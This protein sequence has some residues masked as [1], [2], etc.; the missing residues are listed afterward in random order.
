MPWQSALLAEIPFEED[1][2][3]YVLSELCSGVILDNTDVLT[4]AHCMFD[5]LTGARVPVEDMYI[6][7]GSSDLAKRETTEQES[8]AAGV[9]VHPYYTYSTEPAT[10]PDDVAV[11]NLGKS[12]TFDS[13]VKPITLVAP[14][15][16]LQEDASLDFTGYGAQRVSPEELNSGLYYIGLTVEQKGCSDE[17]DAVFLCASAPNGTICHG[18]SGSGLTVPGPPAQLVGIADAVKANSSDPCRDNALDGF[19]NVAAPEIQD[20]ID[21]DE[22]PPMAPRGGSGAQLTSTAREP[23]VGETVTCNQGNWSGDPTFTYTFVNESEESQILQSSSSPTYKLAESMARL[24]IF[25]Q[26]EATSDGGTGVVRAVN[27]LIVRPATPAVHSSEAQRQE[28]SEEEQALQRA[29]EEEREAIARDVPQQ[30]EET[31]GQ[32]ASSSRCIVPSL[33]G[34]TIGKAQRVLAKAHCQL[35]EVARPHRRNGGS[36]VVVSQRL[37][38]GR[39]VSSGTRVGVTVGL[40]RKSSRRR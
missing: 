29:R 25:C 26:I 39:H 20:F 36:M 13:A 21:G 37:A 28:K 19:A 22:T 9:R 40:V 38:A 16:L 15:S 17:D 24:S 8:N 3:N 7:A 18:D 6:V 23:E 32:R 34:D 35:G 10:D 33:K 12:L 5:P 30:E 31:T 27:T 11:V 4:A 14:G 1:G 2:K